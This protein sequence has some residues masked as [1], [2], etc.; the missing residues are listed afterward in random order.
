MNAL[1]D[2]TRPL[3]AL[4][5]TIRT[6]G[7]PAVHLTYDPD[8]PIE[9]NVVTVL[10][11]TSVTPSRSLEDVVKDALLF[12]VLYVRTR[13]TWPAELRSPCAEHHLPHTL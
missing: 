2:P 13:H 12:L 4:T 10:G 11:Q 7:A 5:L 6:I 3:P 9:E 8:R 1:D